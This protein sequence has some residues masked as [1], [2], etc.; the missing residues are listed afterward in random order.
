MEAIKLV[1]SALPYAN[2]DL[3]IGHILE[4][5]QSDIWVRFLRMQGHKVAYICGDDT[6]GTPIMIRAEL[7]GIT[8]EELVHSYHVKN[9][10]L[11][12]DYHINYDYYGETNSQT[13]Y[14]VVKQVYAKL[15][16]NNSFNS[17][18]IEQFYDVEKGMF[19]PDRYVKGTCPSCGAHDQYGDN[20]EVCSKTYT[21]TELVNP[22]STLTNSKPELRKSTHLFFD[23]PKYQPLL[24]DWIQSG[25]LQPEV[26]NKLQEWFKAGLSEWCVS[27]DEPYF[28]WRI[29]NLEGKYFYV[30]LDAPIGYLSFFKEYCDQRSL[31][32]LDYITEEPGKKN[33]RL[34]MYHFIGKDIVYFHSLFW[35][36]MLSSANL[37]KPDNIFTHGYVTVNGVKMSK[38]RGTFIKARTFAK[39]FPTEALRYYYAAKLN[40][41][42]NDV[43]LNLED[44]VARVNSDIVNKYINIASRSAGFIKSNF[45]NRL[46]SELESPYKYQQF[47]TKFE[48]ICNY[49]QELN[50]SK[51]IREIAN[52][53]DTANLFFS[54][55]APWVLAKDPSKRKQLHR[56]C[57]QTLMYF[58]A[59]MIL[60]KPILPE[61][62]A[63][64]E[65][66][67]NEA[68]FT[69][70]SL[71]TI[72]LGLSIKDFTPM[73]TRLE[74]ATLKA[75][76]EESKAEAKAEAEFNAKATAAQQTKQPVKEEKMT[77]QASSH[78]T[79][80]DFAKVDLR[81]ATVLECN[82]VE[83]SD[84]LLG[85]KLDLG[86][87][88]IR[89]I[90]S[91]IKEWYGEPQK[92]IGQQV[93]VVFNLAPRK[94]RFG[95]SEGMI[96]SAK[97][98][99]GLKLLT[100]AGAVSPG[101]KI[102]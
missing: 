2:N 32:Y 102:A 56:I 23:L 21:P 59:I 39:H 13:H 99:Q 3:H 57:T 65:A 22:Y 94:M 87:G 71:H 19:L 81:V 64:A 73:F 43:D 50:Y 26:S 9:K 27:R 16:A 53:A 1:T 60:L 75:L 83:G 29:P 14:E 97:D 17:R 11:F 33:K 25:S 86:N 35:P 54:D 92:L 55:L 79:I 51:A 69:W 15:E 24:Q 4:H 6:H 100:V 41:S 40:N 61:T 36:A 47:T 37:H 72:P 28:G 8:P 38:S 58:R 96:L 68:P 95:V 74:S 12:K 49:Y 90:F 98:E 84:K 77:E 76:T 88:E 70:E 62:A 30:W 5:T 93:V 89:N 63:K 78:I 82:F 7:L 45:E 44:F 34:E 42:V 20:C 66:F 31:N 85:F 18:E 10:E 46:S 101:T 91:G 80:D 52:L 67:F 48:E